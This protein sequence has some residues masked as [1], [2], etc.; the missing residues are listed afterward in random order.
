MTRRR[1]GTFS[2][3]DPSTATGL[4]LSGY[5]F[6]KFDQDPAIPNE[7]K[8]AAMFHDIKKHFGWQ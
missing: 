4:F 2:V 7:Y 3:T 6:L 5:N 1:W 8:P